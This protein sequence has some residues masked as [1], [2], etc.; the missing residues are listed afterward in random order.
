[1]ILVR[2][3]EH[4][5]TRTGFPCTAFRWTFQVSASA[6]LWVSLVHQHHLSGSWRDS[7]TRRVDLG[8]VP[9]FV[10]PQQE[11]GYYDGPHCSY[12]AGPFALQTGGNPFTGDCDKCWGETT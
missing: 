5:E 1:M 7:H 12:A 6:G 11:H 9:R 10:M 3:R 2:F 4:P 8:L